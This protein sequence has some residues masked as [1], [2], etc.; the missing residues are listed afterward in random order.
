MVARARGS[1]CEFAV[2]IEVEG[3]GRG[4]V[5][6]RRSRLGDVLVLDALLRNPCVIRARC[7]VTS[8]RTS[9]PTATP[10]VLFDTMSFDV[11]AG[12]LDP[13]QLVME[14]SRVMPKYSVS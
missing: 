5:H 9:Q 1:R 6:D 11:Q 12:L 4:L 7:L 13:R 8:V 10:D 3:E 2:I 14:L